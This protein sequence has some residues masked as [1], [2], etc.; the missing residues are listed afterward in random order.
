[1]ADFILVYTYIMVIITYRVAHK[2]V[3]NIGIKL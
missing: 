2:N 1:M 3:L